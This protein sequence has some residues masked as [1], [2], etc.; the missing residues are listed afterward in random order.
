MGETSSRENIMTF[1][2]ALEALLQ[3]SG[4]LENPGAG[5]AA[6]GFDN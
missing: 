5:L 2:G 3:E 6:A 4:C 1:L